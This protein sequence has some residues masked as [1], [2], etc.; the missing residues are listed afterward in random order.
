MK[1]LY[2]ALMLLLAS[3]QF[4]LAQDSNTYTIEGTV[5]LKETGEPIPFAQIVIKELGQWGFTN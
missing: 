3:V 4:A 5:V 2:L 1:K